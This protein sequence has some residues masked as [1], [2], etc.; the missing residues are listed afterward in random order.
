M[1]DLPIIAEDLGD[2]DEAVRTLLDDVQLPGMRVLD[3]GCG[4]GGAARHL[5][6]RAGVNHGQVH[7]YFGGKRGLLEAAMRQGCGRLLPAKRRMSPGTRQRCR[8]RKA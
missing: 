8:S 6:E 7:H 2:I 5:A 3:V 4:W 1:G